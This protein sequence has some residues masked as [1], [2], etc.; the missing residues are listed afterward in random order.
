M[1]IAKFSINQP[2][3][4]NLFMILIILA[5]IFAF[6]SISKEEFPEISLNAVSI[7]TT[8]PGVSPAEIE[9]L[10]TKPIEEEMA[11]I[12]DI[13]NITSFSSEGRSLIS[14]N[15][16]VEA[17]DLYR[18]K[19][20]VQ[21][22]V[23]KV[24]DLPDDAD[25]PVVKESKHYF[26]LITIGIVGEGRER[27]IKEIAEDMVY[28]FKKIYGVGEVEVRGDREREVWVEVDQA[29]LE[30]YDLSL[31][32]VINSLRRKNLNLPGGTIKLSQDEVIVR[33]VGE[34]SAI[35]EIGDIVIRK[36][37][38]GGHV[39]LKDVARINDRFEEPTLL[40]KVN[41]K[42]SVNIS[43]RK[44][45]VGNI[46][47][48]V[49]E[50]KA[51]ALSYTPRLPEG[52]E[53]VFA[54][55]DSIYLEK[56]LNLLYGNGVTG[57][58]LVLLS[59]FLFIGTRSAIV[60]AFGLPVAFCASIL[61]MN[62]FNITINAFSLFSIIIVLGMIVDDAI[63]VTENVYRY[64]EQGIPVKEAARRGAEE[65]FWPVT[66]AVTTTIAAFMPMLLMEGALGKFMAIIPM[67]VTF[68]LLAS[69]WEA[70]FI[71]PSHLAEF[72][73]PPAK[74][75]SR[76]AQSIWFKSL[77]KIYERLLR[78]FLRRR[79]L[80]LTSIGCVAVA[81][82]FIAFGTM[83]FILF[84]N[85]DFDMFLVKV[86][87]PSDTRIEHTGTISTQAEKFLLTIPPDEMINSVTSVGLKTSNLGLV[88]GGYD[89]GS[90]L[91][92]VKVR[93][94]D[95]Q[96]RKL[97]GEEL[98]RSMRK[99][100]DTLKNPHFF[101][102]DKEMAG[103]PVGKAVA[104]RVMGD[105]FEILQGIAQTVGEELHRIKGV[106]DIENDFSL[107]KSEIKVIVDEDKAALYK[108]DVESVATA[109]QYAYQGG[110]AT[111]FKD[112][113]DEID[114]VVKFSEEFRN[115]SSRILD[116]K[117]PNTEGYM[118][119]LKNVATLERT[120]GYAKIRRYDQKRVIT[121]TANIESGVNNSRDVNNA[122]KKKMEKFMEQYPGY[123]L[124]Y[125]G[126]YED[127]QESMQSLFEAF[128][129]A[130]FLIYMIIASTFKS[131]LQ[132]FMLMFTIPLA[133]MGVFIGL[134]VMRTPMGMMSFLGII[135][136]T[137]IVVNDSIVLID[138]INRRMAEGGDRM[139]AIIEASKARLRPIMLTSIT[140]IVGLMPLALGI[141]GKE[142]MLTPMAI[143][144]AWGLAFSSTLTLILIP[145]LYAISDDIKTRLWK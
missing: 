91:A 82:L 71:L 118:I 14:V 3:L 109:M 6:N 31:N 93:L 98:L 2:V 36:S 58:V 120:S 94:V 111:E 38:K 7:T 59:L 46:V 42:K 8:Y 115:N 69:L 95:Y 66:A 144:I 67:V 130:I 49:K 142:R 12:D 114:V 84:P 132:P 113:N 143:S 76:G 145:C 21:T 70:F 33:T 44:G 126:E 65:V 27:D 55:D 63:I 135:A 26:H 51:V 104:V 74:K 24:T 96:E 100:L 133:I 73:R 57:L 39:Y 34:F 19:Q 138:F 116:L 122:I 32:D 137:G 108:L 15:F 4:V 37:E 11:D 5:G 129:L 105:D 83:D 1:S 62:I 79:Y 23:D 72:A 110:L 87:A 50:V 80:A 101:R 56:K 20:E 48:I 35:R 53:I 127:T 78:K 90:N 81:I 43:L 22:E 30:G 61:L 68:A 107:G 17:G 106:K 9:E 131:F 47:D 123:I 134:I 117:I 86:E 102:L 88:D 89:Y 10:I 29:R 77:Q 45:D 41:G 121:V 124:N 140:T 52:T 75:T 112:E 13:D 136:L 25:D 28:D 85:R 119:A 64:I 40:A 139:E 54:I 128:I 99:M 103:P 125:G 92:M 141:F 18:K 97:D 16:K 60:T